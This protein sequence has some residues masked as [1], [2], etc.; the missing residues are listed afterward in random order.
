MKT[1]KN[2]KRGSKILIQAIYQGLTEDG[3]LIVSVGKI[4][5][6]ILTFDESDVI[7]QE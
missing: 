7:T 6:Y 3:L 5:N 2:L 1:V 4:D